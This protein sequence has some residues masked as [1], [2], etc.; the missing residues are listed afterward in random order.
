MIQWLLTLELI[1]SP[2]R[3]VIWSLVVVLAVAVFV[4]PPRRI[5]RLLIA[6]VAG[7]IIGYGGALLLEAAD[8]FQGPLP[9]HAA[10]WI[11]A[12]ISAIAVGA[13][14]IGLRP[15]WR[16]ILALLL[17][18]TGALG[19]GASVNAEYGLTGNLA[20]I[21]GIQALDSAPLPQAT[22]VRS[23][24]ATLYETWKPPADMPSKGRVS[25]L[26]GEQKIPAT[27]FVA[28]DAAL[29][30]PPAALVA[31]PPQLPLLV[32]MMGQ[33]GTPDPTVL[34]KSLDAFAAAHDG[35]APIA[36]VADQL[37]SVN[38]DPACADSTK[39]GK[40][41]TYL[42]V[43]VPAYA[44]KHLNIIQDPA[45]WVIGGYSNGGACALTYGAA[46]P[47]T[48]GN[49]MDISGNEYPGSEHV[50]KTVT[51]VFGGDRAAF[52]AASPAS[53]LAAH[54]GAYAGHVA[55]FT[56]GG[57]DAQFGPG[58]VKNAQRA[59]AAGFTVLTE[60]IPGEGHTG[61]VLQKGL[62]YAIGALAPRLGLAAPATG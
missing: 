47:Q 62:D 57:Q 6:A 33:P 22:A 60:T 40:V 26:S 5:R 11:A 23:D 12:G 20:A 45:Y 43:D 51:E 31:D 8:V 9:G 15:W 17:V 48:W 34:A 56:H 38:V 55:V 42:N 44:E 7:G 36:I 27:G 46:N 37:G 35:L 29:Y 39:Y 3:W 24:P 18:V 61:P 4:V 58:Q 30:L 54:A 41:S 28:R 21:L 50:D 49:L 32:F 19:I 10:L 2:V 16:R 53:L 14:A 1:N 52:D 59:Q 25:A 13:V